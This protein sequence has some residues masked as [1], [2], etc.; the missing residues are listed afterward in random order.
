MTHLR[1]IALALAVA[2]LVSLPTANSAL[3]ALTVTGID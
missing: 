2:T 3:A 1:R